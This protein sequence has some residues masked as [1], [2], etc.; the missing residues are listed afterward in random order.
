MEGLIFGI[1]RYVNILVFPK[2]P[3]PSEI[4][5]STQRL[6]QKLEG[7]LQMFLQGGHYEPGPGAFPLI[8]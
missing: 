3:L 8:L 7:K 6:V 2:S 5:H 4:S 1:L